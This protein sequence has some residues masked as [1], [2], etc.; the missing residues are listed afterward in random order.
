MVLQ[1][2]WSDFDDL[3]IWIDEN[4]QFLIFCD[5]YACKM[6]PR[7]LKLL[8]ILLKCHQRLRNFYCL[9]WQL[10][11]PGLTV[12]QGDVSHTYS[13]S[14]CLH[15]PLICCLFGFVVFAWGCFCF[16][17][18]LILVCLA[19]FHVVM[20]GQCGVHDWLVRM[21]VSAWMILYM[22]QACLGPGSA[23]SLKIKLSTFLWRQA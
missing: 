21:R 9:R 2:F 18:P 23:A 16:L 6:T 13:A 11:C 4:L 19:L 7:N 1:W 15:H 3:F 5:S 22:E 20:A 8:K 17:F 10:V 14:L 12:W